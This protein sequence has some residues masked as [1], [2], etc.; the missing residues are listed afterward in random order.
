[1]RRPGKLQKVDR[2]TELVER[3]LSLDGQVKTALG[4][5]ASPFEWLWRGAVVS[6]LSLPGIAAAYLTPKLNELG[7]YAWLVAGLVFVALLIAIAVLLSWAIWI[8]R[9]HWQPHGLVALD[10]KSPSGGER[11]AQSAPSS[12]VKVEAPLVAA[13]AVSTPK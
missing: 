8:I 9:G 7:A 12:P 2:G 10:A 11:S 3:G 1:M 6:F 13:A 5:Q 4:L